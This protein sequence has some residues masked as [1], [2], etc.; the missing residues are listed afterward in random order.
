M[1][2]AIASAASS[3]ASSALS[4]A[5]KLAAGDGLPFEKGDEV[6]SYAGK[7]PESPW[8]MYAGKKELAG[9]QGAVECSVFLY[10]VKLKKSEQEFSIARNAMKKMRTMKHPYVLR[11]IE[12]GEKLDDKGGGFIY[13]LTEPVQPLDDV[14]AT[15]QETP[16]GLA[17]GVYTLAAAIKFLNIDC[18]IVHGQVCTASLFVDKGMDWKLGGF[19]LLVESKAADDAYFAMAKDVLPKRYQSPEL[20]RGNVDVRQTQ[21]SFFSLLIR[22]YLAGTQE[23]PGGRGLVGPRVHRLRVLLRLYPLGERPQEPRQYAAF[24]QAG[25]HTHH[26]LVN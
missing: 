19:E 17:W 25:Q 14:L 18:N 1:L 13:I 15:L 20:A 24:P 3:A 11:C 8:K 26:L 12:G 16:G 9:G 2:S 23:D 5:G 10:D 7:H 4:A 22:F 21:F 6:T